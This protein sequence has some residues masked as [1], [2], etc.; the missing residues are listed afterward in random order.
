M[1]VSR[2]DRRNERELIRT[3]SNGHLRSE[4]G[5]ARPGLFEL[6][7]LAWH[8]CFGEISPPAAVE[9][10]MLVFSGG[11]IERLIEAAHL[12]VTDWRDLRPA[13]DHLR[14]HR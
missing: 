8:D 7:E 1:P 14:Q 4:A 13:A 3:A 5:R 10:D 6:V 2:A 11:S 12:A 9:E